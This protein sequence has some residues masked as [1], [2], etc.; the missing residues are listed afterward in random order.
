MAIP[1]LAVRTAD[2]KGSCGFIFD[3]SQWATP[4]AVNGYVAYEM[5]CEDGVG[6]AL[7][8]KS[9]SYPDHFVFPDL[10]LSN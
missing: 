6:R 8:L 5:T 7:G 3:A 1:T 2:Q 10:Q 9:V 4:E